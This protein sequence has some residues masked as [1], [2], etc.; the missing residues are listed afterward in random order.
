MKIEIYISGIKKYNKSLIL[1][2]GEIAIDQLL[3]LSSTNKVLIISDNK[4][5]TMVNLPNVYI[6]N[7]RN[8]YICFNGIVFLAT[9]DDIQTQLTNKSGNFIT[10]LDKWQDYKTVVITINKYPQIYNWNPIWYLYQNIR[11]DDSGFLIK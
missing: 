7:S 2:F 6:L 10:Q 9:T 11:I 4:Q 1:V 5:Y 8:N 3:T